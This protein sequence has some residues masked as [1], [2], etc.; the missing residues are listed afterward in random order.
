MKKKII[1]LMLLA[2]INTMFTACSRNKANPNMEKAGL[3]KEKIQRINIVNSR[4]NQKYTFSQERSKERFQNIVLRAVEVTEDTKLDPDFIFDFY[5]ETKKLGSFKYIAGID[6]KDVANLIDE[7]NRLYHI[8]SSIENEFFKRMIKARQDDFVP[9]YYTSLI[10]KILEKLPPK[11]NTRVVVD[12]RKDTI[13]TGSLISVNQKRILDNITKSGFEVKYPGEIEKP[14]Y[15]ITVT[16][17]SYNASKKIADAVV[18]V[19]DV[20]N[21]KVGF[22]VKLTQDGN[23]HIV[24]Q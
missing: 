12:I 4:S 1:F 16:T 21:V 15:F 8:D 10:Q 6:S 24:L 7:E 23:F 18:S 14:D 22:S 17:K 9:Q 20:N 5:S 19:T 3:G 11:S 2:L 13:V